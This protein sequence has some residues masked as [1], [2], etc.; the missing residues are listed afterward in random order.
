[1]RVRH[2]FSAL[3]I[4]A[5]GY[6]QNPNPNSTPGGCS[7][8]LVA[9]DL[10]LPDGGRVPNWPSRC[11]A[12]GARSDSQ[13]LS[14]TYRVNMINGR[15]VIR[16]DG[17]TQFMRVAQAR[18]LA[19]IYAVIRIQDG[20]IYANRAVLG[21][22]SLYFKA[23]NTSGNVE[24]TYA[25][26]S[27]RATAEQWGV[28]LRLFELMSGSVDG[29]GRKTSVSISLNGSESAGNAPLVLPESF[30]RSKTMMLLGASLYNDSP[31]DFCACDL[32]ELIAFDRVLSAPERAR[33]ESY[34]ERKYWPGPGKHKYVF[35]GFNSDDTR[36]R[37]Q[38]SDDGVVWTN[39]NVS[40]MGLQMRD[41]SIMFYDN[42][43][44]IAHTG[45]GPT[46]DNCGGDG[47]H[48]FTIE[49]S[50]YGG[51]WR[52]WDSV[53][54]GTGTRPST[55]APEWFIDSDGSV[56]VFVAYAANGTGH[57]L[58][59]VHALDRDLKSWSAPVTLH[60]DFPAE[61]IDPFVWKI[62]STY[63]MLYSSGS[64]IGH[65][66]AEMIQGQWKVTGSGDWAEW[67][68]SWEGPFVLDAG[69]GRWRVYLDGT[70]Q[71]L[72][73]YFSSETMDFVTFTPVERVRTEA[74]GATG[75][76]EHGTAIR[77]PGH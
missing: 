22:G 72:G 57:R 29:A 75:Y 63:H 64:C 55:W 35:A 1:M 74:Y 7:L 67:G 43:W 9:D 17:R 5:A 51:L 30:T 45:C 36:L 10:N 27:G 39:E 11:G 40:H 48:T 18:G 2:L 54:A 19:T 31:T 73:G 14:P 58:T 53:T 59:E 76:L 13:D 37:I 42:A 66:V 70:P 68:C 3:A 25:A 47:R 26:D 77:V 41:P 49:S 60:G 56:H 52:Y 15:P 62:G 46:L 24:V 50:R 23:S 20:S 38:S 28:P 32:A 61:A 71:K 65:A 6:G 12:P 33:M 4:L 8:W 69:G 16:F 34:F 44:W 21:T